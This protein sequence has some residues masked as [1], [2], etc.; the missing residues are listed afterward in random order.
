MRISS[1]NINKFCGP[2]SND[3]RYYNPR[4]ID[5]RTPI[6]DIVK[7]N[8]KEKDDIFFLGRVY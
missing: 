7:E 5:F 1:F 6:R 8:L 3:G 2:Y 4:N